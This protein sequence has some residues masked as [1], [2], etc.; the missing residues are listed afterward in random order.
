MRVLRGVPVPPEVRFGLGDAVEEALDLPHD[1]QELDLQA[2]LTARLRD[3][4]PV[5]HQERDPGL[6]YEPADAVL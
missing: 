6:P 3:V 5:W 1:V 4:M 2:A